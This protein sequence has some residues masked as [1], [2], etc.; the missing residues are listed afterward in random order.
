MATNV[1]PKRERSNVDVSMLEMLQAP[2]TPS[3]KEQPKQSPKHSSPLRRSQ[4]LT[5]PRK[6]LREQVQRNAGEDADTDDE[7]Q[8]EF[9]FD[10]TGMYRQS[11]SKRPTSANACDKSVDDSFVGNML[12]RHGAFWDLQNSSHDKPQ[13]E[14]E[15]EPFG[16]IVT[17]K[18]TKEQDQQRLTRRPGLF[19]SLSSLVT[20]GGGTKSMKFSGA[21]AGGELTAGGSINHS[22]IAVRAN[23]ERKSS[24]VS[25]HKGPKL[26]LQEV[27]EHIESVDN[28][29]RHAPSRSSS[30]TF[31]R[32]RQGKNLKL[33]SSDGRPAKVG[34]QASSASLPESLMTMYH[35]ESLLRP[36]RNCVVLDIQRKPTGDP[37]EITNGYRVVHLITDMVKMT[38]WDAVREAHRSYP[39][40][41]LFKVDEFLEEALHNES[42][43]GLL[44]V[45][46]CNAEKDQIEIRQSFDYWKKK[47][48]NLTLEALLPV[49]RQRLS[50][51]V[52]Y[53]DVLKAVDGEKDMFDRF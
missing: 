8:N 23:T 24:S 51:Q 53:S 47:D 43:R 5:S 48:F 35:Q 52:E 2:L 49:D 33:Q 25:Q 1:S 32:N 6:Q 21:S 18:I 14:E 4:R 7:E 9:S 44:V 42:K 31:R 11:P 15:D 3:S 19:R 17:P 22:V 29:V 12:K 20:R 30:L 41:R 13:G 28:N 37:D 40:N 50:I 34:R 10:F 27:S 16:P 46:G 36:E 38:V 45:G 39:E 26:Q